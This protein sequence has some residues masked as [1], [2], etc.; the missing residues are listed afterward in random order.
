MEPL[1][2]SMNRLALQLRVP[3]TRI[4]EIVHERRGITP[5]TALRLAPYFNTSA[6]FWMNLQTACDLEIAADKL[7]RS[8]EREVPR[9]NG[10]CEFL[11]L[12][13]RKPFGC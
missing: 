3:V 1:Q 12:I 10:G 7:S 5:R 6:A 8:I 9:L 2:L 11:F 13:F 4:A